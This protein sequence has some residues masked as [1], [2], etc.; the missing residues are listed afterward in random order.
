VGSV[1]SGATTEGA[2]DDHEG[3]E[4]AGRGV[5]VRA[6]GTARSNACPNLRGAITVE[7]DLPVGTRLWL[8]GCTKTIAGGEFVSLLVEIADKAGAP[9]RAE[10]DPERASARLA[11]V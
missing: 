6:V 11:R 10:E 2:A 7:C 3:A 5:A 1:R 9:M 4:R 8:T